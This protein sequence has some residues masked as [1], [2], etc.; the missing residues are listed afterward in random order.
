[1]VMS[2]HGTTNQ[3]G[4]GLKGSLGILLYSLYFLKN[5]L[6]AGFKKLGYL[7]ALLVCCPLMIA[8]VYSEAQEESFFGKIALLAFLVGCTPIVCFQVL[9]DGDE[10][11]T[12][13]REVGTIL[14]L[15]KG[16]RTDR[17][18]VEFYAARRSLTPALYQ[19]R[20]LIDGREYWIS[21]DEFKAQLGQEDKVVVLSEFLNRVN[22]V[23]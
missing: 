2:D 11:P 16:D 9:L 17:V 1:M 8:E 20:S 18:V 5:F 12:V 15:T 19:V 22:N 7:L 13:P 23:Q 10:L 14:I 21:Q 4:R 6:F 3:L